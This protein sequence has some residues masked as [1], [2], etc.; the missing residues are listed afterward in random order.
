MIFRITNAVFYLKVFSSREL[1]LVEP[2]GNR[3]RWSIDYHHIRTPGTNMVST[4]ILSSERLSEKFENEVHITKLIMGLQFLQSLATF[5][6]FSSCNHSS[7][8]FICL[9]FPVLASLSLVRV[10]RCFHEQLYY[11]HL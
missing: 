6:D 1:Y 4:F 7:I 9:G 11:F 8:S 2:S 10:P 5:W 3:D